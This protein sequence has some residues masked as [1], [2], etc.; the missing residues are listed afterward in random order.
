MK[1][2][3]V[4]MLLCLGMAFAFPVLA[5]TTAQQLT[6]T[7]EKGDNLWNLAGTKLDDSRQW[8]KIVE[9]N[10]FLE[11]EGRVFEKDGKMFVL[12]KPGEKLVGLEK[13]G[14]VPTISLL[15][16]LAQPSVSRT[17]FPWW[18]VAILALLLLLG[19][20]IHRMLSKNA[21]TAGS[22]MVPEGVRD[23]TARNA[24]QAMATRQYPRQ[25]FQILRVEVGRAWG[26]LNT[27]YAEKANWLMGFL[28]RKDYKEVPR[29][30][31]GE[32]AYR[33]TVQFPD[34]R[35]EVLHMLQACGND[36]RYGGI[37]RYI[38]GADFRFE[39][40][41]TQPAALATPADVATPAI[42]PVVGAPAEEV[43]GEGDEVVHIDL[44]G[45]GR[46]S[47]LVRFGEGVQ[48]LTLT[49]GKNGFSVRI[50]EVAETASLATSA[51]PPTA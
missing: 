7:V 29:R 10:P 1:R 30:L 11:K 33:A 19:Y 51:V 37:S 28:T 49:K 36:L 14:I 5:Q 43:A 6:Y 26:I 34:R 50:R 17:N 45:K 35:V 9:A 42:P 16:S 8:K 18:I 40:D 38:P 3:I 46:R 12:V 2:F 32:R 25:Q 24:L 21:A 47:H 20:L 23:S 27:R 22:A 4:W 13:L 39:A 48:S 41:A 31:N 44:A 15:D